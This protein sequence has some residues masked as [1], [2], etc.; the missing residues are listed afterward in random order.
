VKE[1]IEENPKIVEDAK[2]NPKAIQALI[3]KCMA[4]TKGQLDP[5]ITKEIILKLIK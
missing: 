3:G 1:V 5:E 2:K 4:K